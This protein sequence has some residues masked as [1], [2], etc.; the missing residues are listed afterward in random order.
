VPESNG[1]GLSGEYKYVLKFEV[2]MER[3]PGECTGNK[4]QL[5]LVRL[6]TVDQAGGLKVYFS[7]AKIDLTV[8]G[9]T[10]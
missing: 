4:P 1:R 7:V 2:S 8:S 6:V 10:P 9:N 3:D 5:Q